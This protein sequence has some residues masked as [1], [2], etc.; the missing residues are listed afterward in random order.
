MRCCQYLRSGLTH[1]RHCVLLSDNAQWQNRTPVPDCTSTIIPTLH[2]IYRAVNNLS[3]GVTGFDKIRR[4]QYNAYVRKTY[5]AF[6]QVLQACFKCTLHLYTCSRC[7]SDVCRISYQFN[8][9]SRQPEG[10]LL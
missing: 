8:N 6:S 10:R 2:I 9:G 7:A 5:V 1:Q 3:R 4:R